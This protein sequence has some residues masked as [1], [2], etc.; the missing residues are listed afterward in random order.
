M[1]TAHWPRKCFQFSVFS[2][3][4]FSHNIKNK[5]ESLHVSSAWL[6]SKKKARHNVSDIIKLQKFQG[7]KKVKTC[8]LQKHIIK[9]HFHKLLQFHAVEIE[10]LNSTNFNNENNN[11]G[12]TD[13]LTY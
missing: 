8:N 13:A 6:K 4:L 11:R 12:L 10:E 7:K 9:E 2:N 5:K 3:C 1:Q